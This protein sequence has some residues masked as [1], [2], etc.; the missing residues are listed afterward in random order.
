MT[1]KKIFLA[2]THGG[3]SGVIVSIICWAEKKAHFF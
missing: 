3:A 1:K 2:L